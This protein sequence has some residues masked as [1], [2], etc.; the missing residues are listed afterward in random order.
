MEKIKR[1]YKFLAETITKSLISF[2][3]THKL[4]S[5]FVTAVAV[6]TVFVVKEAAKIP[7]DWIAFLLFSDVFFFML[8]V[9]LALVLFDQKKRSKKP[10]EEYVQKFGFVWDKKPSPFC[11]KCF[12][13]NK[14]S[15]PLDLLRNDENILL[16]CPSCDHK[17][18]MIEFG[19]KY[20]DWKNVK[21]SVARAWKHEQARIIKF[22]PN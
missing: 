18:S 20:C 7:P 4:F 5:L 6:A 13:K 2:A 11:Y 17:I 15:V 1:L 22:S 19:D 10:E 16:T 3:L 21:A 12:E 9:A 8:S 14:K